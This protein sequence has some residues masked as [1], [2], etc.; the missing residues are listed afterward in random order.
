MALLHFCVIALGCVAACFW[1]I[2]M[3]VPLMLAG[4]LVPA[5]GPPIQRWWGK[6]WC[7][8]FGVR[9]KALH[10]DRVPKSG[11]FVLAPNHEGLFDIAIMN[12]MPFFFRWIAKE[13]VK[14]IPFI[15]GANKALGTFFLKR[16][17]SVGDLNIMKGVEEGLNKGQ[18]VVIFPEGT[19]SRTGQLL[20]LK[21]GAFRTAQNTGVLL[22]PVAIAGSFAIAHAGRLPTRWG[23]QVVVCF[24]NPM[25]ASD[26][27]GAFMDAYRENL[28]ALLAEARSVLQ[29]VL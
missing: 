27:L 4:R 24:G 11:A 17:R 6:G 25:I 23:H 14:K 28:N 22:L 21:K 15:S 10:L 3:A 20:S 5:I 26:D 13:Q 19:R 16:D 2:L 7:W 18:S 12:S 8:C 29:S 9:I 1:T